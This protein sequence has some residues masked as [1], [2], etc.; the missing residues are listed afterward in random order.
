MQPQG[1]TTSETL[2]RLWTGSSQEG[3]FVLVEP[4]SQA[5]TNTYQA[6]EEETLFRRA[7][8][9][10]AASALLRVQVIGDPSPEQLGEVILE[11]TTFQVIGDPAEDLDARSRLYWHAVS[12]GGT[13]FVAKGEHLQRNSYVVAAQG[14]APSAAARL[15]WR[16]GN[17]TIELE[18]RAWN[19]RQRRAF[20]ESP[21]TFQ[22]E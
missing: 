12:R 16:R 20:L 14:P 6:E 10:P 19:A 5:L 2:P 13:D 7:F 9:V 11:Q 4:L 15:Q 8:S 1:L 3:L 18:P 17:S 22:D 21:A